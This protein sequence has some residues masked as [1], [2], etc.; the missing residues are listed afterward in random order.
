MTILATTAKS[1]AAVAIKFSLIKSDYRVRSLIALTWLSTQHESPAVNF[2]LLPDKSNKYNIKRHNLAYN[3][4]QKFSTTD[5]KNSDK[6]NSTLASRNIS[7]TANLSSAAEQI[8]NMASN[9]LRLS[10]RSYFKAIKVARTITDLDA[11]R[12]IEPQHISEALQYRQ[13]IA[14]QTYSPLVLL[15]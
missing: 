6:Y 4:P 1:V 8:L 14:S 15:L 7:A 5:T 12:T 11:S 13:Q 3:L 10:A 2:S 9:K